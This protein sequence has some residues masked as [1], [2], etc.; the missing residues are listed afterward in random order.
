MNL[1]TLEILCRLSRCTNRAGRR[2]PVCFYSSKTSQGSNDNRRLADYQRMKNSL[3]M[4]CFNHSGANGVVDSGRDVV[5][6]LMRLLQTRALRSRENTGNRHWRTG[7]PLL[8]QTQT[9]GAL[10]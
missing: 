6:R 10:A 3:L 9:E 2:S 8:E 7:M 5:V 4:D 1:E